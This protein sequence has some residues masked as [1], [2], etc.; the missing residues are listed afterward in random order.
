MRALEA[1]L[2][3]MTREDSQMQ[4]GDLPIAV[5][6]GRNIARRISALSAA[7]TILCFSVTAVE[8]ADPACE[9]EMTRAARDY[10][11][12]LNVLYAVGLTETGSRGMLGPYDINVDGRSIQSESLE[13]AL[14]RVEQELAHGAKYIDVGCM[15]IN[16]R[17][18]GRNFRSLREMFDPVVNVRYAAR[19]LRELKSREGSWTLAVARYNAGPDNDPAQKKYVCAVIRNM[20]ASRFGRWTESARQFCGQSHAA[21][22]SPEGPA[23]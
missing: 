17:W 21:V 9:R 16:K 23:N 10:D 22:N 12:P 19:F 15:Q 5:E 1:P 4:G 14:D 8:A 18:H 11:V 6:A 7:L 2:W 20:V 13:R 3:G